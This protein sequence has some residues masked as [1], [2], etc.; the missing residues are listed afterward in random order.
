MSA[1]LCFLA[2]V[3]NVLIGSYN[4]VYLDRTKPKWADI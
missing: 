3:F 4:V 2:G 1:V